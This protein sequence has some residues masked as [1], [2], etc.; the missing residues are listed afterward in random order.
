MFIYIQTW[1]RRC[2]RCTRNRNCVISAWHSSW[3][4]FCVGEDKASP[5]S[6]RCEQSRFDILLNVSRW[7]LLRKRNM[8]HCKTFSI[9]CIAAVYW[10]MVAMTPALSPWGMCDNHRTCTMASRYLL[11][12][13]YCH[14]PFTVAMG[15][16]LAMHFIVSFLRHGTLKRWMRCQ[17]SSW[18]LWLRIESS[19]QASWPRVCKCRRS[20]D[21]FSCI[22]DFFLE[23]NAMMKRILFVLI[24]G[25]LLGIASTTKK[26]PNS[27]ILEPF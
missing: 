2:L 8:M 6:W 7:L 24:G 10:C 11:W 4:L 23:L 1:Q 25:S 13:E 18:H 14:S 15:Y 12:S 22:F 26:P 27:Y 16:V 9:K 21:G 17:V 5:T 3:F 19:F 20:W